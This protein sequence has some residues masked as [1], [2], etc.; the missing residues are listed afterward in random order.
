MF[1]LFINPLS[2]RIWRLQ[3]EPATGG[4]HDPVDIRAMTFQDAIMDWWQNGIGEETLPHDIPIEL[5]G[6]IGGVLTLYIVD[7]LL[8]IWDVTKE[9][10]PDLISATDLIERRKQEKQARKQRKTASG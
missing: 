1:H 7:D 5:G 6:T 8:T 10:D 4:A 3:F 2:E 9:Y